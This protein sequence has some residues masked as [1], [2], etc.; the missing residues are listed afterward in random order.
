MISLNNDNLLNRFYPIGTVYENTTDSRNPAEIFGGGVWEPFAPGRVTVG[1]NPAD[2]DF[3]DAGQTGGTKTHVLTTTQLP[4]H[5][6]A[7]GHTHGMAHHHATST[8]HWTWSGVHSG[9]LMATSSGLAVQLTSSALATQQIRR[10][11]S[12]NTG[13]SSAANTGGPSTANTGNNTGTTGQAHNNLQ[14]YVVTYKWERV[15]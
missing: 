15:A 4:A 12:P 13:G 9:E 14:P 6:H 8:H 11:P 7:M 5:V 2:S 10:M 1:I 3:I